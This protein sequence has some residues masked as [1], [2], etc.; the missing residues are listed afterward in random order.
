MT[1][2]TPTEPAATPVQPE[3]PRRPRQGRGGLEAAF[4]SETGLSHETNEDC[5][6]HYPS[7]EAPVFCAVADGVGGGARGDVAS[8]ALIRHCVEAPEA[9][10]RDAAR[11]VD[12]LRQG[13]AVVREAIARRSD[14]AGAATLAAVW[15][16]SGAKAHVT[17]IG[18]CRV[19]RLR[20]RLFGGYRIEQLT[21][22]QT[23]AHLNRQPPPKAGPNDP[24]CMAG[25][26][27][28][29]TPPVLKVKLREGELLL[30]CSDGLH[31]FV[32]DADL[33]GICGRELKSGAGLEDACRVLVR[34]AKDNHSHD[35]VSA[36]LVRRHRRGGAA[37]G[38]RVAL[39]LALLLGAGRL[40]DGYYGGEGW[41]WVE[42]WLDASQALAPAP[43]QLAPHPPA[44]PPSV[45][46]QPVPPPS[47]DALTAAAARWA[48]VAQAM[49][50][51][52]EDVRR[53]AGPGDR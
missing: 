46:P 22:D 29:G 11:L 18:D 5:C 49:R 2:A 42:A 4:A 6:I 10:Y 14:R 53:K 23:Y 47:D 48:A 34:T 32:P 50:K 51:L 26:G 38:F 16:L 20:P 12:W 30:L 52:E 15:F 33:A 3:P 44:P 40:A 24:A 43:P 13:D 36:L 31:K 7:A 9:V 8:Q 19:Y 17:N 27:A 1:E 41:R 25:V 45:P 39:L 21:T 28:V 37:L 35:D